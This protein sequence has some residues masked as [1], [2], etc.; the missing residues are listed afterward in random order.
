MNNEIVVITPKTLAETKELA[1]I[2]CKSSSIAE[3]FRGKEA[4]TIMAIMM[5]AELGLRAMQSLASFDVIKG[6]VGMKPVAQLALVRSHATMD[7]ID[8]TSSS[9]TSVT[10]E[11][12]RKGS[13]RVLS[14]TFTMA[15]AATAKLTSSDMYQKYPEQMLTWRCAAIHCR[16]FHS[17]ITLGY[18]TT[19]ELQF[20]D[21]TIADAPVTPQPAKMISGEVVSRTASVA[22]KVAEKLK[23]AR[24]SPPAAAVETEAKPTPPPAQSTPPLNEATV[25]RG[26][27]K[28]KPISGLD[29]SELTETIIEYETGLTAADL[30]PDVVTWLNSELAKFKHEQQVRMDALKGEEVPS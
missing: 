9:A 14:T 28:G 25:Q 27:H 17:D 29:G 16:K 20:D 23:A 3:A 4:D 21:D 1:S 7:F 5:G 6:K 10:I 30:K 12:K 2:L 8:V 24:A 19:E 26:K 13:E 18:Y 22:A 11:S 15:Q